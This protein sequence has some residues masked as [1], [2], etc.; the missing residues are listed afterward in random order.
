MKY[1][2]KK[3]TQQ[4]LFQF[5]FTFYFY[6]HFFKLVTNSRK[7]FSNLSIIFMLGFRLEAQ[8]QFLSKT[9][10]FLEKQTFLF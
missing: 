9:M 8:H 1:K 4:H 7:H 6:I 10:I 3:E 5:N 2:K